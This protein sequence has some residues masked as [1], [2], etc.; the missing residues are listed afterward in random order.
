MDALI[1]A[2]DLF[3]FVEQYFYTHI[4]HCR[5]HLNC[6]VV[7]KH[8]INRFRELSSQLCHAVQGGVV[9]LILLALAAL[10]V[11]RV[12]KANKRKA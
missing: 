11:V 8:T 5:H 3:A 10:L 2:N 4:F 6:I 9:F 1:P 12:V 7:A